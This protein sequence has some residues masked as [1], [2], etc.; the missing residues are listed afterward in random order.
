MHSSPKSDY[1]NGNVGGA[2]STY[3]EKRNKSGFFFAG[4]PEGKRLLGRL[5]HRWEDNI[6][7]YLNNTVLGRG[8][9]S[10]VSA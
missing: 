8:F 7:K 6:N 4:K 1:M 3:G 5:R 9:D 2:C 10:S